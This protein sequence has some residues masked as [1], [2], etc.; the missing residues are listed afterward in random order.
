V[1][2]ADGPPLVRVDREESELAVVV[3]A[4]FLGEHEDESPEVADKPG[5]DGVVALVGGD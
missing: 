3:D 4:V 2:L 1:S 5:I